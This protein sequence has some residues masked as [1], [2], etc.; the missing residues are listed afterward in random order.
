LAFSVSVRTREFGIRLAIGSQPRH[1]LTGVIAE[2]TVI[3]TLGIG[4]GFAAV[5]G[6]SDWP[7]VISRNCK[8]RGRGSWLGRQAY[9]GSGRSRVRLARDAS[10]ACGCDSSPTRG[11]APGRQDGF[12]SRVS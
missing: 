9:A 5:L 3:T 2:G 4:A 8:C 11:L 10:R 7:A 6:W 12:S 1:L